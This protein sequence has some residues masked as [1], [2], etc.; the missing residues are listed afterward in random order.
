MTVHFGCTQCG[1]CC[2]GL[3][4]TLSI[5]EAIVWSEQG[6]PVQILI[7]ARPQFDAPDPEDELARFELERTFP[8]V[9][10]DLPIRVGMVLATAFD[11]P[12]PNLQPDLRCGQYEQRPRICRTYPLPARPLAQLEPASRLCPPEAWRSDLPVLTTGGEIA[13]E[14]MRSIIAD[15]RRALIEDAPALQAVS[16]LLGCFR[17]GLADEGFVVLSPAPADLAKGLRRARSEEMSQISKPQWTYV[18]NRRSTAE[19]LRAGGGM[20]ELVPT[21]HGYLAGFADDL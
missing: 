3:K 16:K 10:G 5:D 9:C 14:D 1:K 7:E 21:G 12:C 13:D 6:R 4:L 17:A 20:A 18:T 2:I 8:A 19:T 15:H 11:G